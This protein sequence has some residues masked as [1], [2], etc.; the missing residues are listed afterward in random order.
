MPEPRRTSGGYRVY[1]DRTLA[2]LAFI[3][4][5]KQLG[6]SLEQIADL[7]AAWEGGRR[8][9]V[10]D[11]LRT[12]V[13]DKLADAQQQV[14]ELP[15]CSPPSCSMPRL[16]WSGT[17]PTAPATTDRG[18]VGEVQARPSTRFQRRRAADRRASVRGHAIADR[19]HARQPGRCA[20]GWR[21]GRPCLRT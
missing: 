14:V 1:D 11:R 17:G 4:R 19:L 8:G 15:S 9:P 20:A 13:A 10:Q 2:R 18:C 16:R 6:C 5:A 7:V 21:T 12:V 3:A